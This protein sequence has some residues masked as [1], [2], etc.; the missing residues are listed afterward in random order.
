[1]IDNLLIKKHME[2]YADL[3]VKSITNSIEYPQKHGQVESVNKVVLGQLK[4][5]LGSTKDLWAEKLLEIL[6]TY[7]CT[8]QT[9]TGETPFNLTYGINAMIPVEVGEPTLRRQIEDWDI[10]E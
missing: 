9:I 7:R 3:E 6:W 10:K 8:P 5:R 4:R 1:M 2:F